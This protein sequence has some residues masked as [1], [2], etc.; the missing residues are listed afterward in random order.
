MA[1]TWTQPNGQGAPGIAGQQRETL[2]AMAA[3]YSRDAR[4]KADQLLAAVQADKVRDKAALAAIQGIAAATG[5]DVTPVVDAVNA[6]RDEARVKF[7]ELLT[8]VHDAEQRAA[9]AEAEVERLR[10]A[11]H[12]SAQAEADATADAA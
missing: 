6:V 10:A 2:L 4:A 1:N 3:E 11:L 8:A 7:A 9:A 12:T 5:A